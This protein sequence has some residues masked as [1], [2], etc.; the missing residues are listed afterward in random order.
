M[1]ID[2]RK[3]PVAEPAAV[4]SSTPF[5]VTIGPTMFQRT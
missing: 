2:D 3:A 4:V 1:E 5:A